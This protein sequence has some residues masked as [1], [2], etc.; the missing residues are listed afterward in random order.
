MSHQ[1]SNPLLALPFEPSLEGLGPDYWDVVEA[2]RFPLTR[3]RFRNDD[4]LVQLGLD[5]A[6]ISDGNLEAAYGRFEA[7]TPLLALRYHG[8]QFG[9]YNPFL[10]D[11]RGFLY[12]QLR[13]CRGDLQDLGTKGS[14]T[15]LEPGWGWPPHP[16]GRGA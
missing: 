4:L 13:D 10:G 2:A 16:Q 9:S 7:R 1:R 12:G 5:P 14:G 11:G 3:L 15:T 6:A 8:Y